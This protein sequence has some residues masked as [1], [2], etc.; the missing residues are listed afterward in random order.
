MM[1]SYESLGAGYKVCISEEH[2]F[3]TD[4]FLLADFAG[5]RHKDK[6]CDLC[7][8]NG[9]VALL[10]SR[11]YQPSEIYAV[12][13]QA[14]AYAQLEK[15]IEASP[16]EAKKIL[17]IMGDLKEWTALEKLDLITCNPP[18]KADGAGIRSDTEA[19]IIARHET[20]CTIYDV[21]E[22]AARSLKYGGRLCIC[23]RPERLANVIEAMRKNKIEP[24]RL[25]TVH[26]D[27]NSEPWLILVEGRLGGSAFM[28]IE[29]PLFIKGENGES[30]SEEMKR[31][32]RLYEFQRQCE[33]LEEK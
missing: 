6:V 7:S 25:R 12:E 26:K 32:Y 22:C 10:L 17:P 8:G 20:A 3:G 5:A 13:L 1:L 29:K 18:Y 4:A 31:I 2:R 28:R 33:D 9:I 19:A 23:N 21:C 27:K 11:D 30:Y 15:S 14:E 24:K 16:N